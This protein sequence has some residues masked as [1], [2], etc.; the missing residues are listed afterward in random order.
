MKSKKIEDV[1]IKSKT[2]RNSQF[3]DNN[4]FIENEISIITKKLRKELNTY[5]KIYKNHKLDLIQNYNEFELENNKY[6]K[7]INRLDILEKEVESIHKKITKIKKKKL[8]SISSIIKFKKLYKQ[9]FFEQNKSLI[10][11]ELT[12]PKDNY[13]ILG[14]I[15]ESDEEFIFYL[16]FLEKYYITLEK[17]NLTEYN[18]KKNDINILINDDDLSFPDDKLLYYLS[19]VFQI[20]DLENEL[21]QKTK[22][23]KEEE[24]KKIELYTK[25]RNLETL[26]KEQKNFIEDAKDYID[27]LKNII[28]KYLSYQKKYKN[29]LI[30]KETLYKKI[31]KLQSI[32]IRNFEK[33]DKNEDDDNN[34]INQSIK[35]VLPEKKKYKNFIAKRN[36]KYRTPDMQES[37][38]QNI[39][40]NTLIDYLSNIEKPKKKKNNFEKNEISLNEI[41]FTMSKDISDDSE[42]ENI[43]QS[44]EYESPVSTINISSRK[45]CL[46][47]D[48]ISNRTTIQ[49]NKIKKQIPVPKF[50]NN[51]L[52]YI[53]NK[54]QIKNNDTHNVYCKKKLNFYNNGVKKANTTIKNKGIVNAPLNRNKILI[55][56]KTLKLPNKENEL[57]DI[58]KS[59]YFSKNLAKDKSN[60][61]SINK[62]KLFNKN[63]SK[64]IVME[65]P[66]LN[67]FGDEDKESRQTYE[68]DLSKNITKNS[69]HNSYIDNNKKNTINQI[70][71]NNFTYEINNYFGDI[72]KNNC[73]DSIQT[74]KDEFKQ[75][76]YLYLKKNKIK[77][78][79][80]SDI[81][82][83]NENCCVSCI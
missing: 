26:I 54:F 22:E 43:S 80:N 66:K 19:Y 6:K 63:I 41:F 8:Y 4:N 30:S 5:N 83:N 7:I 75:K 67:L 62:N 73:H 64:T 70:I 58:K 55:N 65:K 36:N 16:N 81:Q 72:N 12:G 68:K 47:N 52:N 56:N 37:K 78:F 20:I 32:N 79:R 24:L 71:N 25:I 44:S 45:K 42:K 38:S 57:I 1:E 59:F 82:N 31:R 9:S 13:N 50:S 29:N 53:N 69:I 23:F 35:T 14:G 74:I 39:S 49:N 48:Q 28:Q 46:T 3:K 18:K 34:K 15:K 60:R 17:K 10:N 27:L 40:R 51:D 76:K 61:F 11:I 2:N 33:G 77:F 21:N